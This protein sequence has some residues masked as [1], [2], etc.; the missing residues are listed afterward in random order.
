VHDPIEAKKIFLIDDHPVVRQGLKQLIGQEP[1][2]TV[3]GEAE[4]PNEA[5]EGLAE[6]RP[7]L[8]ILDL[9][10]NNGDGIGFI[11]SIRQKYPDMAVLVLTMHDETFFAERALRAG[12]SGFLTKQEAS[13]KVLAAVRTL[14]AGD[15]YVSNRISPRLVKRLLEGGSLR[16]DPLMSHLS[17]RERQVFVMIGRGRT[18]SEIADELKLSTKTIETYRGN[19]REKLYLRDSRELTQYAVRWSLRREG[20]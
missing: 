1:D 8:V 5:L 3:C 7:D 18:V 19:I 14:L 10:M 9:S 4:D 15:M 13:D 2:M 11:K 16:D 6:T 17:A 20:D 12:A